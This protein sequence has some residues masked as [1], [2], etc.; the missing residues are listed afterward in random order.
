MHCVHVS[1]C[2]LAGPCAPQLQN[3]EAEA[4]SLRQ[5]LEQTQAEQRRLDARG[6]ELDELEVRLQDERAE[7]AGTAAELAAR[8]AALE[9]GEAEVKR[10]R[11][12][13]EVV[14]GREAAVVVEEQ[15]QHKKAGCVRL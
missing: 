15:R 6:K 8:R 5:L 12:E 13:L 7:L 10:G 14:A 4:A 3:L 9:V 11:E 1:I 2:P